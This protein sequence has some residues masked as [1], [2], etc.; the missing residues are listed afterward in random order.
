MGRY[1]AEMR[2]WHEKHGTSLFNV[3]R[4]NLSLPAMR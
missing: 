2:S 4:S 3:G 1:L